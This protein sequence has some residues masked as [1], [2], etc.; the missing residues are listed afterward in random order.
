M[1]ILGYKDAFIIEEP[2]KAISTPVLNYILLNY[3]RVATILVNLITILDMDILVINRL[4]LL[5]LHHQL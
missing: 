5:E 1:V 4:N 2:H 3:I